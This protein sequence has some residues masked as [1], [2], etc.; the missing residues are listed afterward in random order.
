MID[1]LVTVPVPVVVT[2]EHITNNI[3]FNLF[4]NSNSD[5]I[6]CQIKPD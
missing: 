3:K 1:L 4:V 2:K 5:I 6:L